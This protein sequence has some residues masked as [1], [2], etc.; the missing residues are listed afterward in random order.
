MKDFAIELDAVTAG[1]H[2]HTVFSKVSFAV[3]SGERILVTGSN[4]SGKST[5]L[6]IISGTLIPK[7]GTVTVQHVTLHN[8][9]RRQQTRRQIGIL[10]QMQHDPE[11]AISVRES[12]VLGL[13]GTRFNWCT[14]VQRE[15]HERARNY[16][17]LVDM[18]PF[19]HRDIRSLSGGQH[20]RVALA[21]AL[22]RNPQIILMD[23][24]TTYLDLDAKR[25]ILERIMQLQQQMQFTL[26]VVSHDDHLI[27]RFDRTIR[28]EHGSLLEVEG[29]S[30]W[31]R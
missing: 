26:V 15:D 23:E 18:L 30:L 9:R 13:W 20:Q 7:S 14:R 19:E 24:P 3:S 27:D 17:A 25:D 29:G 21:R 5:L 8:S 12:V 31:A 28:L 6:R 4:G 10:A 22:I 2:H 11:I 1:Y 16:L